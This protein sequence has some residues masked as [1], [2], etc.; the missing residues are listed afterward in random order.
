MKV[1]HV[2]HASLLFQKNEYCILTD[3]WVESVAFGGWKQQPKADTDLIKKATIFDEKCLILIS[4]GHDDHFDDE[5]IKENFPNCTIAIAKFRTPGVRFRA[6]AVTN[7]EVIEVDE[8]GIKWNGFNIKAYINSEYTGDDA[9]FTID[10]GEHFLVHANDN[11]HTQ[12]SNIIVNISKDA[13][14]YKR[15]EISWCSQ[16]GIAG[17]W[18][19]YYEQVPFDKKTEIIKDSLKKMLQS[20]IENG[21]K[22]DAGYQYV[23]ANQSIFTNK[24]D[25]LEFYNRDIWID[26]A[27]SLF[28]ESND[29]HIE[30]LF[31]GSKLYSENIKARDN[32]AFNIREDVIVKTN[33]KSQD[34]KLLSKCSEELKSFEAD[35]N[36]YLS[37]KLDMEDL[38]IAFYEAGSKEFLTAEKNSS[39]DGLLNI[40]AESDTWQKVLL[41]SLNIECMTIGGMCG[42]YKKDYNQN[43]RDI[44]ISLSN[45]GYKYQAMQKIKS[46]M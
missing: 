21:R 13:K 29:V 9:I 33:R 42:I 14:E 41:G 36:K 44:H 16:V 43:L 15:S 40:V 3:P 39:W 34:N 20:G 27:I 30:Q 24:V 23:Y 18:P 45:F 6:K 46:Q 5:F 8:T 35:C 7:A 10:D 26:E 22:I 4:H 38:H 17:S 1:S 11:W 19:I 25:Y 31:P 28:R 2:N 32:P 12:P 37:S